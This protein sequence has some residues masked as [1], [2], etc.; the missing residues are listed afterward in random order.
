MNLNFTGIEVEGYKIGVAKNHIITKLP[1]M[2]RTSRKWTLRAE[3]I[4]T[5][6]TVIIVWKIITMG[7][8]I[9][10][11]PTLTLKSRRNMNRMGKVRIKLTRLEKTVT[12]GRTCGGNSTLV[13]SSPPLI[14][15]FA[16]SRI[17]VEK[18]TQ[19]RSPQNKNTG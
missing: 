17:D 18:H 7:K 12:A 2:C 16:P 4:R 9:K 8:A 15:E 5:N 14:I 1:S 6:P 13:M 10:A 11:I 19:G 3:N